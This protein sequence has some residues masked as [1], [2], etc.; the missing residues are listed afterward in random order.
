M[1]HWL[2]SFHI[3]ATKYLK[4]DS[5]LFFNRIAYY[6]H[7]SKNDSYLSCNRFVFKS[8]LTQALGVIKAKL[9]LTLNYAPWFMR[10]NG[11]RI[12]SSLH[13]LFRF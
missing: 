2:L 13:S 4:W 6:T 7:T 10:G 11:G 1:T 8:S 5:L 12:Y 9:S 3:C